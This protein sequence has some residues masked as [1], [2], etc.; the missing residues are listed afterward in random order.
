MNLLFLTDWSLSNPNLRSGVPFNIARAFEQNNII[1]HEFFLSPSRG[2]V[3]QKIISKFHQ[4]YYNKVFKGRHGLWDANY[5]SFKS[6]EAARI[7]RKEVRYRSPDALFSIKVAD[8]AFLRT[9]IPCYL[10]IDNTYDTYINT[11]HQPSISKKL[12][13]QIIRTENESMH[14]CTLIFTASNW[15]KQ[16]IVTNYHIPEENLMVVERGASFFGFSAMEEML[17]NFHQKVH[18]HC[19]L[20]FINTSWK[21]KGGD[22]VIATCR[23]LKSKNFPFILHI[24]GTE[25][26]DDAING[27]EDH[28][29]FHGRLRQNNLE[30]S[31][32]L[33]AL[34][35][36]SHFLFVPTLA[37]GF[38][39]V[40]A[41][42]ASF[43]LPAIATDIMGV[44]SSVVN[45]VT[46]Y[47]FP[48]DTSPDEYARYI[49]KYFNDH[50]KYQQLSGSA[51]QYALEKFVWV[52][53][54]KKII[55]R[56]TT[57]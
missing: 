32:K 16:H 6:K 47:R 24:A 13:D 27:L 3:Y 56:I 10:W 57:N 29:I 45:N 20:L 48:I 49:E 46:G 44:E 28:I 22:K 18:D 4:I 41:E 54:V 43:G 8:F 39:I 19:E 5:E 2:N 9:D 55:N 23:E 50:S 36:E 26:P 37:D 25:P 31:K 52:K 15:L 33:R 17:N 14:K 38:G 34:F 7:V 35:S 51:Y 53:N 30:E 11:P 12:Y 1:P 42:A 40:Y 21:R